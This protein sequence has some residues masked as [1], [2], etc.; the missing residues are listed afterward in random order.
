MAVRNKNPRSATT[1]RVLCL[2]AVAALLG[3]AGAAGLR[4][5]NVHAQT[6]D[7]VW[8]AKEVPSKMQFAGHESGDHPEMR[9]LE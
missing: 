4:L 8:T 5:W 1:R 9:T 3:A 7:W 2:F 6:S